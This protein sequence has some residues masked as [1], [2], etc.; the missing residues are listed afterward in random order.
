MKKEELAHILRAASD[1][2]Q[3]P[4]ILVIGSPSILAS[5]TDEE[6]P[7]EATRSIEAD[8]AFFDDPDEEKSDRVD[9]AIGELSMFHETYGAYGQGAS[10]S[11]AVL[12]SGW[13]ERLVIFDD[14]LADP[15]RAVCLDPHDL[16]VSKL[17]AGRQK[18]YEFS[19]ALI[20]A[21]LIQVGVV[22]AR[23]DLLEAVHRRKVANWVD[24]LETAYGPSPIAP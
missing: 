1:I 9:G 14:P 22:R 4:K 16:V 2:A 12:P 23:I 20:D 5:F 21:G 10:L 7:I 19:R 8:I 24:A 15:S 17:V 3:D 11:T 18:D 13:R 6:L